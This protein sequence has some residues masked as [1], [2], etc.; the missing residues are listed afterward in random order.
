MKSRA[1]QLKRV[2]NMLKYFMRYHLK[3]LYMLEES[4][5]KRSCILCNGN[6]LNSIGRL[7]GNRCISLEMAIAELR[8]APNTILMLAGEEEDIDADVEKLVDNYC[9]HVQ[10]FSTV[11]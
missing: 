10:L 3:L 6:I 9:K 8:A 7:N 2:T 4:E 11:D 1:V 5:R